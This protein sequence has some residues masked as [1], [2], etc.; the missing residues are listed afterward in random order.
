MKKLLCF[1]AGIALFCLPLAAQSVGPVSITGSTCATIGTFPV[2]GSV[3]MN[4]S[5]SWSGTINTLGT[6]QGQTPFTVQV[7]PVASTTPQTGI[8]A[9]G[10]YVASVAALS[11]FQLCGSAITGTAVVY[12]N[13]SIASISS[14]QTASGSGAFPFV[15]QTEPCATLAPNGFFAPCN[16]AG[17]TFLVNSAATTDLTRTN[18]LNIYYLGNGQQD[19]TG[20]YGMHNGLIVYAD[21]ETDANTLAGQNLIGVQANAFYS[22]AFQTGGVVYGYDAGLRVQNG[23]HINRM[24]YY[25]GR[26]NNAVCSTC[27]VDLLQGVAIGAGIVAGGVVT[28]STGVYLDRN[29]FQ[30]GLTIGGSV[31]GAL[32]E[33]VTAAASGI[34]HGTYGAAIPANFTLHDCYYGSTG[35]PE[36]VITSKIGSI[37]SRQDGSYGSSLYA[38]ENGTGNTGYGRILTSNGSLGPNAGPA[39]ATARIDTIL[40]QALTTGDAV[41]YTVPSGK[42]ATIS[43]IVYNSSVGTINF[44]PKIKIGA[45]TYTLGA[46]TARTQVRKV[47]WFGTPIRLAKLVISSLSTRTLPD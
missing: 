2:L 35:S 23:A 22:N 13:G 20:T 33:D 15:V 39:L 7:T 40:N 4:I 8:T 17:N 16:Q 43:F 10:V 26:A 37:F 47:R 46:A 44:T 29:N 28:E 11:T 34:C 14:G 36:G 3:S 38:K 41:L 24:V 27:T 1:F 32:F 21:L 31:A 25:H 12:M 6:I 18:G 5:G 42:R 19:L 9:N 45:T 30:Y